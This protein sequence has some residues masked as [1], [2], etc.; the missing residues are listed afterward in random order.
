MKNF[1]EEKKIMIMGEIRDLG[2]IRN[3]GEKGN[4]RKN[5]EFGRKEVRVAVVSACAS[6]GSEM[7]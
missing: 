5:P 2:Y 1:E 7:T 6:R 4:I 3:G